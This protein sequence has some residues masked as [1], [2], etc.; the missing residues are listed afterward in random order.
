MSN[1]I[2]GV[3]LFKKILLIILL[4][5]LLTFGGLFLFYRI[6]VNH[7]AGN[8]DENMSFEILTGQ[9]TMEIANNLKQAK[10]I[11]SAWVF[12]YYSISHSM[13]LKPGIY[14]L[15]NNMKIPEIADQISQGNIQEYK[16]T[17]IEGWRITEIADYLF[18]NGIINVKD[19]FI[20]AAEGKEGYLFPDTYRL[21]IDVTPEEIVQKM[22]DNY[23]QRTKDLNVTKEDLILASI[24]EREAKNDQQRNDI[25]GVFANRL[26][27]DMKLE[28]CPTVSFAKN[29]WS[30]PTAADL[31]MVDSPYNTYK[32]NGLPPG[33]IC[34]PG[35][36]SIKAAQNPNQ[37]NY[38]YFLNATN[39]DLIMSKN[40]DEHNVNKA[41]YLK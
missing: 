17:T 10:I 22:L 34:N 6:I 38:Y 39:G 29:T 1:I 13:S 32:Y 15:K 36:A 16:I 8:S 7:P 37:H 18:K 33:P 28:S 19:K 11:K 40:L 41:K 14:Y 9:G 4:A 27:I 12:G 2:N 23:T 30:A 21:A 20:K 35:L 5:V 31:E 25:A 3:I 24:V 26:K